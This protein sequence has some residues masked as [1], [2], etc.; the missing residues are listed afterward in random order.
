MPRHSRVI[1]SSPS[2][3]HEGPPHWR[4]GG[5]PRPQLTHELQL[6]ESRRCGLNRRRLRS[7]VVPLG[8]ISFVCSLYL[9]P[10]LRFTRPDSESGP[11]ITYPPSITSFWILCPRKTKE[12][13][14]CFYITYV[15][16]MCTERRLTVTPNGWGLAHWIG[17][18]CSMC[19]CGDNI[20]WMQC[21]TE[22]PPKC[23]E[24]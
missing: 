3:F 6:G 21:L 4:T 19:L 24:I 8:V 2:I 16:S 11:R 13:C 15:V 5:F 7:S 22:M 20:K 14:V 1:T 10:V 9:C 23:I 12:L 17:S 18:A